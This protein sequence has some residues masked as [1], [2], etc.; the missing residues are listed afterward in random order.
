MWLDKLKIAIIEKDVDTLNLLMDDLP[1]LE[2]EEDIESAIFLLKEATSVVQTLQD[3][4]QASMIQ[5]K[6]NITFL[7]ATQAPAS[8]K[9]DITS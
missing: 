8:S 5:M 2:K 4:T 3:A 9:L 6:K 1:H 7:K